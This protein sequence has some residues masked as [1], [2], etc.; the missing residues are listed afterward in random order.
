MSFV[1]RTK[2]ISIFWKLCV[3]VLWFSEMKLVGDWRLEKKSDEGVDC[4]VKCVCDLI[5]FYDLCV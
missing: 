3:C 1:V 5:V 2:S 4:L